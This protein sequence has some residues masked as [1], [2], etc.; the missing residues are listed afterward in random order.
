[1]YFKNLLKTAILDE[2][3]ARRHHPSQM[4]GTGQFG[5]LALRGGLLTQRIPPVADWWNFSAL[6][7]KKHQNENK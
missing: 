5:R 2:S 4:G 6:K 1:M 3:K 7:A